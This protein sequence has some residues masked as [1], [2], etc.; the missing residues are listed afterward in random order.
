MAKLPGDAACPLDKGGSGR[1]E[2]TPMPVFNVN[3]GERSYPVNVGAGALDDLGKLA[4]G[5]GLEAGRCAIITDTNIAPRYLDR[6]LSSLRKAGFDAAT[7]ELA[8]GEETKSLATIAAL[9]ERMTEER[10]DRRSA[11]FALGGG[12]IGD[13]AGFAAATFMRGVPLVH[14][15]TSVVAQVDSSL[16]GKTGVNLRSAKNLIGAFYQPRL[17]VAD[18]ATLAS[19]PQ[20]EFCEG[21]AEVIKYGAIVD[22][23][24][25]DDLERVMPA[26]LA[27]ETGIL[28]SVVER[29]LRLK[30]SVVERDERESG[31]RAILNFGHT[32][33]H[34]LEAASGY[35]NYR[36]GEAVAI[37]MMAASRL[38]C[39]Y[40]G[41]RIDQAE[42]LANLIRSAGLPTAIPEGWRGEEFIEALK[43]DKKRA[44]G[45][46]EFV[47]ISH[48]GHA[49]SRQLSIDEILA[50]LG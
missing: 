28:E 8:P 20:R 15:P 14:V 47:L 32:V 50:G 33:G 17:V 49:L 36:H 26:I 37:G 29:S 34:A 4:L 11:V 38:S 22:A 46:V 3:L 45:A 25:L 41:L 44:H 2:V 5:A 43:L 42:R 40:A 9:Y 27:R 6:A 10:L 31:L 7:I 13:V 24:L 12:V 30:A 1:R 19:L 39:R 35:G 48:L 16:G 21:L 18:V 23:A